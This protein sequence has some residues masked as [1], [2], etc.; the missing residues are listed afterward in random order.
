MVSGMFRLLAA[1]A[2]ALL[3]LPAVARERPPAAEF[4]SRS[5]TGYGVSV[6]G[7]GIVGFDIAFRPD[8]ATT[9][10]AGLHPRFGFGDDIYANLMITAG[11]GYFGGSKRVRFGPF[12]R[13]GATLPV[14][15]FEAFAAA[16]AAVRVEPG[17]RA[18]THT[19]SLG[20]GVFPVRD[21]PQSVGEQGWGLIYINYTVDIFPRG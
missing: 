2:L 6:L 15:W 1:L 11:A 9:V 8:E 3:A 19:V 5:T 20:P 4:G 10:S 18:T 21:I 13:A 14:P 17:S 16:G 7:G 12:V